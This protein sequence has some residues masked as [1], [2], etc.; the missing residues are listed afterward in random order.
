MQG[1]S[2]KQ[3]FQAMQD[4]PLKSSGLYLTNIN[5]MIF[6]G[7]LRLVRDMDLEIFDVTDQ[8]AVTPGQNIIAKPNGSQPFTF[9][10]PIA[11]NATNG[12]LSAAFTGITGVY[13]VTFSDNE[14][15][16]VTLTN[17]LTTATWPLPMVNAA[18]VNA[19]INPLFVAERNLWSIYNGVPKLMVKRS[20]EFIQNYQAAANGKPIYFAD[21]GTSQWITAPAADANTSFIKRRYIQ[22]PQSIVVAQNTY[23][24]DNL[25]DVLFA[26]CLMESEMFLKADD[27]YADMKTKYEQELLPSARGEIAIAARAG[28]YSPLQPVASVPQPAGPPA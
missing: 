22:R 1:F 7:E 10:A 15:Q 18:T 5:R 26:A 17:G 9:T 14:I 3:L 21:Q 28:V 20:W 24:G 11:Q 4:W 23:F 13:V 19:V 27:R 25:G 8:V 6:M 12:T 2:Y 16:A